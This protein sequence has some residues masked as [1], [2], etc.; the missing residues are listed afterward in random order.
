MTFEKEKS[1]GF[2][3]NHTARL[4]A[5]GLLARI[6][7]L[8]ITIGQFPIL[9]ELWEKDGVTQ[10]ELVIKLDIEQATV[11]NTLNRM[12]R[13]DLIVRKRHPT[14]SRSQ[15]IWLTK[16]GASIRDAAYGAANAQNQAALKP[17]AANEQDQF[18][19]LMQRI[20]DAAKAT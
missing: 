19:E 4:F 6:S 20:I 16:K 7:P 11:A 5:K 10:S 14:D 9:L 12:E 2:L 17:L 8:G 3:I 18:L 15:Q 1:A 13:D